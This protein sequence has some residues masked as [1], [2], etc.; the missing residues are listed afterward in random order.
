M[1]WAT[2]VAALAL[3]VIGG[4][5][6]VLWERP[7]A[8]DRFVGSAGSLP[9]DGAIPLMVQQDQGA[10]RL[11]WSPNAIGVKDAA[12]GTLTITDGI[13]H[14][15]LDLDDRELRAGL[16]SYWPDGSRVA[17]RLETDLGASGYI[18]APAEARPAKPRA[19]P[20][21]E[22]AVKPEPPKPAPPRR[23]AKSSASVHHTKPLDDGLEWT[24]RPAR[25]VSHWAR[26]RHKVA[27]WRKPHA[28]SE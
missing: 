13:H 7:P 23:K 4:V 1:R 18:E 9:A 5:G 2:V 19:E 14:S 20:K 10:M 28:E 21:P 25:H 6:W 11:R 8:G 26:L 22:A 3:G 17:F 15:R 24:E 16:A 12:H 27:Y